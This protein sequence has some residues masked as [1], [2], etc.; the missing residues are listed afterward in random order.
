MTHREA[1]PASPEQFR[2][3]KFYSGML[4]SRGITVGWSRDKSGNYHSEYAR[5]AWAA[6]CEA[7]ATIGAA[8]ESS[9]RVATVAESI[10]VGSTS[11]LIVACCGLSPLF[12]LLGAAVI[13]L[14]IWVAPNPN[15]QPGFPP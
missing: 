7:Q 13:S 4:S 8:S 5:N 10:A 9:R 1:P 6:W 11:G 15:D 14:G 2:M 12:V 3:E